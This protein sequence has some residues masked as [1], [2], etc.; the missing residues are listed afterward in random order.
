MAAR[1]LF[2][3]R[4]F[5]PHTHSFVSRAALRRKKKSPTPLG[6]KKSQAPIVIKI[7][8]V[9][10]R[11]NC[12]KLAAIDEKN[13]SKSTLYVGRAARARAKSP[14]LVIFGC[15]IFRGQGARTLSLQSYPWQRAREHVLRSLLNVTPVNEV[16]RAART[17]RAARR[18]RAY[19]YHPRAARHT[20]TRRR[21]PAHY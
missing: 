3:K 18:A 4:F 19:M 17:A 7:K 8:R 2:S 6:A 1:V 15:R 11:Q 20:C 14:P 10:L 21:A 13:Q 5:H 16:S 9:P 12:E